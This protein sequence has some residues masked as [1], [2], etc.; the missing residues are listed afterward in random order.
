MQ[1]GGP[2]SVAKSCLPIDPEHVSITYSQL[3][4]C[5]RKDNKTEPLLYYTKL[6]HLADSV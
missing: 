1:I 5:E 4:V 2:R 6:I 3:L